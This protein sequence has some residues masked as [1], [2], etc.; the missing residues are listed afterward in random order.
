MIEI[1]KVSKMFFG[2]IAL[3]S[4]LVDM[5]TMGKEVADL[6][7]FQHQTGGF[8]DDEREANARDTFRAIWVA[9]TY[10]AFPYIDA[11]ACFRW[12]QTLQN[13]DGGATL[14]PGSKSSVY[15]TYLYYQMA[16]I[17]SPESVDPAKIAEYLRQNLVDSGLFKDSENAE[18]SIEATYYA[19]ELL[20]KFHDVDLSW[21]NNFAIKNY[22]SDH[23]VDDHFE[24]EGISTLK[25]QLYAG[26]I[27]KFVSLTVPFHRISEYV[28][29]KLQA[30]VKS[31]KINNEEAASGAR[32]LYIFGDEAIPASLIQALKIDSTLADIYHTSIVLAASG[33]ISKFF[34]IKVNCIDSQNK[35][36]NIESEGVNV[37][38]IVRPAVSVTSLG[39][40]INPLMRVNATI[41]VNGETP[42]TEQLQIDYQTGLFAGQRMTPVNKLGQMK[43][44]IVAWF[45]TEIGIP[46]ISTKSVQAHVSL[47]VEISVDASVEGEESIPVGGVL[48]EGANIIAKV[49]SK[50]DESLELQETTMVTFQVTDTAGALIYYKSEN[51]KEK[52]EFAWQLP[53]IALPTGSVKITIEIGDKVNG[54][55]TH[56]EYAY[57]IVNVMAATNVEVPKDLKLNDL[58]KVKMV[59]ALEINQ[60]YTTFA[61]E[62]FVEGELV[63]AAGEVFYPQTS[64][65][66]QQYSMRIKVGDTVVKV[67]QGEVKVDENNKLYV[68]FESNV[69]ENLDFAT[70]FSVDF[71][72]NAEDMEPILL[73]KESDNFVQVNA[74]I[75]GEGEELKGGEVEYGKKISAELKLKEQDSGKY[76]TAGRAYPVIAILRKSDKKVLLEKK[77]KIDDNK[78]EGKI[79]ISAA[80]PAGEAIVAIMIRKGSELIQVQTNE[81][82]SFEATINVIGQI[83]FKSKIIEVS[84]YLIIDFYTQINGQ[85]LRGT[86]FECNLV[87]KQGNVV[88]T[89]PLAQKKKGS[90]LSL[91][92]SAFK[93]TYTVE[94]RRLNSA[95]EKPLFTQQISFESC[96]CTILNQLPIEAIATILS[97]VLFVWSIRLRKAIR[98]TR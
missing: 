17:Y 85:K 59:P 31:G 56:K 94:L 40:F 54:I 23:L 18:P 63:D 30:A 78:F 64:S 98:S 50:I 95:D 60:M 46:L 13:R 83:E 93:G 82:K 77:M 79:Q 9:A 88:A 36:I 69:D 73:K 25:A 43:V 20:S 57:R 45:T 6:V 11:K 76:L 92:A 16:S 58:L 52:I 5:Y 96:I 14:I 39:R 22:L 89:V 81:G 19:Y 80:V 15:G 55:H 29:S 74:K 8:Y 4:S 70:G 42:Y 84:K 71:E 47:P 24:F 48:A 87:D 32:L 72:F 41:S 61:N 90:R 12:I 10:G 37:Q 68:E 53:A 97:F 62:K 28:V 44:D 35:F 33:E 66:T 86:A 38:Q 21:A 7:R 26:S 3:A 65:E 27:A 2:I 51:F 1:E 67:V 34:D 49:D 75:V 91:D